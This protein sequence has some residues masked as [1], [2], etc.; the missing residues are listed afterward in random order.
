MS[1]RNVEV[2]VREDGERGVRATRD[3]KEGEFVLEFEA[4]LL[5][6]AEHK[7]AREIY[8]LEGLQTCITLEV[9]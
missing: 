3:I 4:T 1:V 2:F 5:S 9:S 6:E 8:H 7:H